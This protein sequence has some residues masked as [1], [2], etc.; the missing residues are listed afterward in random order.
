[1]LQHAALVVTHGGHGTVMKALAADVPMVLLPH[2]RDQADTAVR[3]TS[4]GAGITLKRT[5]TPGVIA[6]AVRQVLWNGSYRTA[7]QQ[8]GDAIRR[9]ANADALIRE[10]EDMRRR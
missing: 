1:V 5:V 2:G 10:L 7:A 4:R 3:V 6:D 8:L 9:D